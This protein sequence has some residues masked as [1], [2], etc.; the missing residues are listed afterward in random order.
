MIRYLGIFLAVTTLVIAGNTLGHAMEKE[1]AKLPYALTADQ[2]LEQI[3]RRGPGPVLWELFDREAEWDIVLE[4]I[5]SGDPIWLKVAAR[6]LTASDAHATEDLHDAIGDAIE[7]SPE[8]VLEMIGET[9][10]SFRLE[11][12]CCIRRLVTDKIALDQLMAETNHK[13]EALSRVKRRDLAEQRDRCT[14]TIRKCAQEEIRDGY[15]TKS[16]K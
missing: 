3:A 16:Q 13:I 11:D 9:R 4:K 1:P 8:L 5:S 2:V 12:V 14:E 10:N 7:K 15:G 6:F